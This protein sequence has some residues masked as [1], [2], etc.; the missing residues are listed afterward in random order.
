ML[1]LLQSVLNLKYCQNTDKIQY[2]IILI[3]C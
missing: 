1:Q 3:S 2:K